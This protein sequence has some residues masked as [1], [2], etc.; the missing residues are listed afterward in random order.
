[1]TEGG[2]HARGSLTIIGTGIQLGRDVSQRAVSEIE[3]ADTV[4]CLC[5]QFTTEWLRDL[6]SDVISLHTFY[7]ASK[8]RRETYRQMEQA[9]MTEVRSGKRVCAIFYGHPGVFADAPHEC[10]RLARAEGHA[11]QMLPGVSAAD[12]LYADLGLDP[13]FRGEQSFEA[14][15]FLVYQ[16]RID[17]TAL[18][19]LWQV[20]LSGDLTCATFETAPERLQVLVNKLLTLYEPDTE[21]ILYEAAVLPVSKFRAERL[22]LADLPSASYKE[23]TTLVIPPTR[24]LEPDLVHL[25]QLGKTEA[26]LPA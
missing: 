3:I 25:R 4:F 15:Q 18:L 26:D 5:D 22:R 2:Q 7:G 17:S 24:K 23:F 14:T 1:M 16:H 19:I 12:C 8:D 9:I 21:V 20:A 10:V 6:R 13:G 11:A